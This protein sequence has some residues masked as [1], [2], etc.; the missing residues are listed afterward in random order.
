MKPSTS[1]HVGD[2][3]SSLNQINEEE[4]DEMGNTIGMHETNRE[5]MQLLDAK[6]KVYASELE[7]IK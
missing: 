2:G 7:K 1:S 4:F 3:S 6:N 5:Q